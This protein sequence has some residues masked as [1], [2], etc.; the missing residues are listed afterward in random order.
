MKKDEGMAEART[1]AKKKGRRRQEDE[2][3]KMKA[4]KIT[5]GK[6]KA[7]KKEG[8]KTEGI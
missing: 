7:G 8:E 5:A 3:K 1:E 2:G 6:T 4:G